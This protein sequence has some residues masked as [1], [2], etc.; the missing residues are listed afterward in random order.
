ML[1]SSMIIVHGSGVWIWHQ[2]HQWL[3][4]VHSPFIPTR[5][6][7]SSMG[8]NPSRCPSPLLRDVGLERRH[9]RPHDNTAGP[10]TTNK[11]DGWHVG[12]TTTQRA[13]RQHGGTDDNIVGPTTTWWTQRRHG[14]LDDDT[15]GPTTAQWANPPPR[16]RATTNTSA[17][18]NAQCEPGGPTTSAYNPH[19]AHHP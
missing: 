8:L 5:L 4:L 13:Q 18:R 6:R 12:P 17:G 19:L 9:G 14:G 1:R 2:P 3:I 10:M 16:H 7:R 15:V 11:A